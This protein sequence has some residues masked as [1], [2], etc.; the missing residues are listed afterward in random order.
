MDETD[1][2]TELGCVTSGGDLLKVGSAL[3]LGSPTNT[4]RLLA[5]GF[6][7]TGRRVSFTHATGSVCIA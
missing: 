7:R 6:I 4:S 1:A 5:R 3:A 2:A